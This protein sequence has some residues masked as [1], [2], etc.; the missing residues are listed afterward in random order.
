M[1]ITNHTT[2]INFGAA[3]T[4]GANT[5]RPN[6]DNLDKHDQRSSGTTLIVRMYGTT[7]EVRRPNIPATAVRLC[8][9]PHSVSG[10][11]KYTAESVRVESPCQ[12]HGLLTRLTSMLSIEQSIPISA[13]AET[14]NINLNPRNVII[15]F[16][17]P[18]ASQARAVTTAFDSRFR[19][20]RFSYRSVLL[21]NSIYMPPRL[22]AGDQTCRSRQI[23]RGN[24]SN[25]VM[26]RGPL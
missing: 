11:E 26:F 3:H 2:G 12:D 25:R 22:I 5:G 18:N 17:H 24:K 10:G 7:P 4:R 6:S 21:V 19:H 16:M 15:T 9:I 20:T 1:L 23:A 14:W 13:Q 8:S